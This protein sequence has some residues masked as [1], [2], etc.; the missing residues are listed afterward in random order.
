MENTG[1]LGLVWVVSH[2]YERRLHVVEISVD[3]IC[4]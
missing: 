1:V 2:W 3:M 4:R